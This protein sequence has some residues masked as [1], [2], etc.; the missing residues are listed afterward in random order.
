MYTLSYRSP[1][2]SFLILLI[3]KIFYVLYTVQN[4]VAHF[5]EGYYII[6]VRDLSCT[7]PSFVRTVCVSI[8]Y[9]GLYEIPIPQQ[10]S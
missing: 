4:Y 2:L 8:Q 1:I 7:D 3:S 6:I 5:Q 10:R 9:P